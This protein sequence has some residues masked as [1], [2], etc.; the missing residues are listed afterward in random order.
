LGELAGG[1]MS[2][3][4]NAA[5]LLTVQLLLSEQLIK[6]ILALNGLERHQRGVLSYGSDHWSLQ[7]DNTKFIEECMEQG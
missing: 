5:A 2:S 4:A 6:R 1:L 7:I 3:T